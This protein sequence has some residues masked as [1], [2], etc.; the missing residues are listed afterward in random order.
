MKLYFSG[1]FAYEKYQSFFLVNISIYKQDNKFTY[2]NN[3]IIYDILKPD[4]IYDKNLGFRMCLLNA[5]SKT[6]YS[7]AIFISFHPNRSEWKINET[8]VSLPMA[9]THCTFSFISSLYMYKLLW[10]GFLL[11]HCK[12]KYRK[13]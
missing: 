7:L 10:N 8:F 5:I 11:F 13:I 4:D 3:K 6:N 9:I 12:K 1:T 2:Q